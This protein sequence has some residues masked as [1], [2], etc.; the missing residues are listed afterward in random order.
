MRED[1]G[2]LSLSLSTRHHVAEADSRHLSHSDPKSV[3]D[4]MTGCDT[5]EQLAGLSVKLSGRRATYTFQHCHSQKY[6]RCLMN[7]QFQ[8]PFRACRVCLR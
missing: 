8:A 5:G 4:Q 7:V 1:S 6:T 3:K 2:G